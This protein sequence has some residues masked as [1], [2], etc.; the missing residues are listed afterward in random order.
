MDGGPLL[1]KGP[2]AIERG[3]GEDV[4]CPDT[5]P[6]SRH[7]LDAL[8]GGIAGIRGTV[9]GADGCAEYPVGPDAPLDELGQHA[10]L[11]GSP[12][13]AARQNEGRLGEEG[14]FLG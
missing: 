5:P 1:E 4:R 13:A 6:D 12:A 7:P 2:R 8:V 10:D 9:D 14:Q 11:D 3:P